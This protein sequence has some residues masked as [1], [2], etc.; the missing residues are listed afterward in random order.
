MGWSLTSLY[1]NCLKV[2][3]TSICFRL[4]LKL[5]NDPHYNSNNQSRYYS[6]Q[7]ETITLKFP[8]FFIF[9]LNMVDVDPVAKMESF[10][11]LKLSRLESFSALKR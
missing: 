10:R 3:L 4:R 9:Y 7:L 5:T 8:L 2:D 1:G 11:T 6:V